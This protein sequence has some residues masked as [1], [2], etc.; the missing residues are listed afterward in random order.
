M[1]SLL[2]GSA[3]VAG[4][5]RT[6]RHLACVT[7]GRMN[8]TQPGAVAL[9]ITP[10]AAAGGPIGLVQDGD[11]I[12]LDA[13]QGVLDL[14]VDE[15]ELARRAAGHHPSRP[16]PRRGYEALYVEHVLQADQGCDLDFL[17]D[18]DLRPPITA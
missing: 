1:M 12:V 2:H 17:T 11:E 18:P 6:W 7:D 15:Q 16:A 14:L 3:W 4:V 5:F 10:E 8:G 9:H 13:R